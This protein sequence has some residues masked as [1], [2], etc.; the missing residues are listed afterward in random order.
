MNTTHAD[1]TNSPENRSIADSLI[2]GK[3]GSE[4]VFMPLD[5]RPEAV[6][7]RKLQ[8]MADNSPNVQQLRSY[9]AMADSAAGKK[10][11]GL[12]AVQPKKNETGL[13]DQLKAGIENLSGYSM[14]DV[15]VH[16]NSPKPAQLQ[17]HAF[18]QGSEI[19]IAP[20]QEQHLPH[21]A[22]HVVQQ[23][24]GR[25]QPTLQM[26]SEININDDPSLE[27]E[28]DEMGTQAAAYNAHDTS[29]G[30]IQKAGS[31]QQ[32][33]KQPKTRGVIQR[34][35]R[36][37]GAGRT[38]DQV[39]AHFNGTA[40]AIT[41]AQRAILQTWADAATIHNFTASGGHTAWGK[42]PIAVV[43][44][45][46]SPA[47][48]P[49]LFTAANLLFITQAGGGRLPT[50]YFTGGGQ[51]GRLRQQ[52][53][54]GPLAQVD[55]QAKTRISFANVAD[56]T[57]YVNA[58]RHSRDTPA[59][60]ADPVPGTWNNPP[61]AGQELLEYHM[62]GGGIAAGWHPSEGLVQN[63]PPAINNNAAIT[64]IYNNIIGAPDDDT[65]CCCPCFITT[66]CVESKGLPDDCEELKVLREY[67]DN[68]L[69]K[70]KYGIELIRFYYTYAPSIVDGINRQPDARKIYRNLYTVIRKC[71]SC[72]HRR[73]L[74]EAFLIYVK[75]VLK[76]RDR[77]APDTLIPEYL[78]LILEESINN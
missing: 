59:V 25:V 3:E 67:R 18:A 51:T 45:E 55:A 64:G 53:G 39:V 7:Q 32:M 48:P 19:N 22:W 75:M 13:P 38:V 44:A 58:L 15:K 56:R 36:V 16:F 71:V 52:H 65:C 46:N 27:K 1:K 33:V 4:P 11:V 73:D 21:E 30:N 5:N 26:K 43:R 78:Q 54:S 70:H 63:T 49:P 61:V 66:A 24:Q 76:L 69:L 35:I 12:P 2:R 31:V 57:A 42:I 50:L 20:G 28:A 9:Q 74:E 60:F 68:Y 29:G 6:A 14:D 40:Q 77:Y 47:A 72:I 37:A 23:K 34:V 17:A 41:P 8:E 62:A 10:Q